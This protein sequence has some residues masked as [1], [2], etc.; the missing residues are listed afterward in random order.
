[1][2][3]LREP[4]RFLLTRATVRRRRHARSILLASLL[5]DACGPLF[6]YEIEDNPRDVEDPG[7][8]AVSATSCTAD[9]V[10]TA[11]EL[12]AGPYELD[13][14]APL[15]ERIA[16]EGRPRGNAM[17]TQRGCEFECCRNSCGYPIGCAYILPSVHSE[18]SSYEYVC[19]DH[20]SF[21][22]GGN[23]CSPYCAP[24][25]KHPSHDYR[26]LGTLVRESGMLPTLRVKEYCRVE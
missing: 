7:V 17:C 25:S 20:S 5:L 6:G 12:F 9:T 26:F 14:A 22:C 3:F 15:G 4:S 2:A 1:M 18:L 8:P 16:L 24:L 10:L 13:L 19:L 21:E 23:D 11:D